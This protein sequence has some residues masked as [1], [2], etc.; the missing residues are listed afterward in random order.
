MERIKFVLFRPKA[1]P[2]GWKCP[3]RFKLGLGLPWESSDS[4]EDSE[5]EMD[6]LRRNAMKNRIRHGT[7]L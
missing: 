7:V 6:E 5:I 1:L 4:K 3:K 2:L